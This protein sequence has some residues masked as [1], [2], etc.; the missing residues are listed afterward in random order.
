MRYKVVCK[1]KGYHYAG[2]Q[3][4]KNSSTIQQVIQSALSKITKSSISIVGCSRTDAKVSAKD[5]VFH[6]DSPIEI[7]PEIFRTAMNRTFPDDIHALQVEVV[8]S[9][10]HARHNSKSKVYSYTIEMGEYNVFEHEFVHQLNQSLD[11]ELCKQALDVFVGTH[12]FSSFNSTPLHVT[13]N[14]VRIITFASFQHIG[15]KVVIEIHGNGFLHHMVRMIVQSIIEVG[16]H[17]IGLDDVKTMLEAK[18]KQVCQFK[19]PAEGLCLERVSY[20]KRE[21]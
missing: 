8:D 19:A 16:L 11:I 21:N 3:I 10:F 14:Q 18:S 1:F 17:R 15:S 20:E 12:D 13:K 4:Q 5:F 2:W 9:S 6:F 7:E